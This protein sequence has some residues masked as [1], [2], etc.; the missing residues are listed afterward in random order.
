[1]GQI[2]GLICT[3]CGCQ[4]IRQADTKPYEIVCNNCGGRHCVSINRDKIK[5]EQL[6]SF[7]KQQMQEQ[8]SR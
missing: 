3:E 1:M 5:T 4:D 7:Y 8:E 6:R 2:L